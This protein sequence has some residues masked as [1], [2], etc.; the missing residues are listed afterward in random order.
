MPNPIISRDV[1]KLIKWRDAMAM[2]WDGEELVLHVASSLRTRPPS[3]VPKNLK[4]ALGDFRK[5]DELSQHQLVAKVLKVV[6][7]ASYT[8]ASW[9]YKE[10]PDLEKLRAALGPLGIHVYEDPFWKDSDQYGFIFSRDE[11]G[12]EQLAAIGKD[13]PE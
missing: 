8:R 7:P 12:K 4:E 3:S 1:V 9:D 6:L 13:E 11:L 5:L 2:D 10:S